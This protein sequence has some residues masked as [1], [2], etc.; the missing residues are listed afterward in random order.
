MAINEIAKMICLLKSPFALFEKLLISERNENIIIFRN[1]KFGQ[2]SI[3]TAFSFWNIIV[4]KLK[5]PNPNEILL[6]KLK[7]DLKS[8]LMDKQKASC[9]LT[10]EVANINLS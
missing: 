5:I 10:W 4:K 1:R 7:H 8:N 3:L 2:N 9:P 6:S